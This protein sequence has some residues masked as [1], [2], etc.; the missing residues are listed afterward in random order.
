MIDNGAVVIGVGG[1]LCQAANLL[2]WLCLHSPLTIKEHHHH[3][4][5]IFPDSGRVLPFGSG[6]GVLYN[7]GDLQFQNNTDYTFTLKIWL[8]DEFMHGEIWTDRECDLTYKVVEKDH[9]FYS[10]L[11]D[12]N[13][14]YRT[15]KLYKTV[16]K[17]QG[18]VFLRD[19]LITVNNSKVLY[20][21]DKSILRTPID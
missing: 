19:E 6:A 3:Q 5:D 4:V 12:N 20:S 15:N 2:Y 7:Y 9:Y 13:N 16:M 14:V 11:K 17:R 8:D 21:V 1:G 18:G 10:N